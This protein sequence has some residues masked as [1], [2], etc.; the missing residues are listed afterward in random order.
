MYI[1]WIKYVVEVDCLWQ[2]LHF[3]IMFIDI[4]YHD[5][6]E[7]AH[8]QDQLKIGLVLSWEISTSK[9]TTIKRLL[10]INKIDVGS[11]ST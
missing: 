3:F 5:E 10:Q 6:Y 1:Q 8:S 7:S 4:T 2:R 9:I 11:T